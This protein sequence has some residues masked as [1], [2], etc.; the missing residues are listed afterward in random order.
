MAGPYLF[1][2]I[3]GVSSDGVVAWDISTDTQAVYLVLGVGVGV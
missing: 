1:C 3:E 2:A